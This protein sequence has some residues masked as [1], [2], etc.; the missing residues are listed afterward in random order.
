MGGGGARV[1]EEHGKT[2]DTLAQRS[3]RT[4]LTDGRV[5]GWIDEWIDGWMNGQIIRCMDE[6]TDE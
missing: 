3:P 4:P 2:Q 5:D 1:R 6:W